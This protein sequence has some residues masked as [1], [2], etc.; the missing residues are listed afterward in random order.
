METW[1]SCNRVAEI[2]HAATPFLLAALAI[3]Q[4]RTHRRVR[5]NTRHVTAAED[6]IERIN[7]R[8][9]DELRARRNKPQ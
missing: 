6:L 1:I 8:E 5:E 2:V 4:G 9:R 7:A 3:F